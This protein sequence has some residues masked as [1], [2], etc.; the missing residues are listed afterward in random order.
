M[1]S[2]EETLVFATLAH[3]IDVTCMKVPRDFAILR[4]RKIRDE[5]GDVLEARRQ[6]R[7]RA[8]PAPAVGTVRRA[9]G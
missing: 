3:L 6:E 8:E 2:D 9:A 7:K 4:G 1:T 5:L